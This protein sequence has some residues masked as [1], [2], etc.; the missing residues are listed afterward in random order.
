LKTLGPTATPRHKRAPKKR[1]GIVVLIVMLVLFMATGTAVFALQSAQYEQRSSA[2]LGEANWARG[3]AECTTMAGIAFAEDPVTGGTVLPT[4]GAQW[5]SG[6]GQSQFSQKYGI[7]TPAAA[8]PAATMADP[9]GSVALVQAPQALNAIVPI[10]ANTPAGGNGLADFLP[11]ERRTDSLLYPLNQNRD[12]QFRVDPGLHYYDA[13][14][15]QETLTVRP[16][17]VAGVLTGNTRIRTVVTGFAD[18]RVWGDP[19]DSGGVR[20]THELDAISR[21]Y[22]DRII[23]SL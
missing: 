17:N 3:I 4:L 10:T 20:E 8:N 21:G 5:I 11:S 18:V 23:P 22:I 14:W 16:S 19:R 13:H 2:S 15:L 1:E 12:S 6:G 7:P 9:A